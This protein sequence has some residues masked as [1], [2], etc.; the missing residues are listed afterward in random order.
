[1]DEH[2]LEQIKQYRATAQSF[3]DAALDAMSRGDIGLARTASRQAAQY[4]RIV[5]QLESG[6][7]QVA[8]SEPEAAGEQADSQANSISV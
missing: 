5:M 3:G 2:E 7:K 1:M 8:P 6:E 4:A